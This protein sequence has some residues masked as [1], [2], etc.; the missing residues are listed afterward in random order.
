MKYIADKTFAK[1]ELTNQPLTI[2]E[3]EKCT[4]I[5]CEFS[6]T[7]LCGISFSDCKF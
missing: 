1:L 3:Y 4:L 6:Y 2:G 5:N 7:D